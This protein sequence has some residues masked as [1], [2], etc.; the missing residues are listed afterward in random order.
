M[1]NKK[2]ET[3]L[4]LALVLVAFAIGF[5]CGRCYGVD[6]AWRHFMRGLERGLDGD[7]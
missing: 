3:M 4:V 6:E 2:G 5:M 1:S 7:K